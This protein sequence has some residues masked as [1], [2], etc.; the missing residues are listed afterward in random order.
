MTWDDVTISQ[1]KDASIPRSKRIEIAEGWCD[2]C[3]REE[4]KKIQELELAREKIN[5]ARRM[6]DELINK[7]PK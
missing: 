6:L 5:N 7:D 1:I 4:D 2:T 3:S